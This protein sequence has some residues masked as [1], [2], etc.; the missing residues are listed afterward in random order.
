L[1]LNGHFHRARQR[2][3]LEVKRTLPE[4]AGMSANDPKRTSSHRESAPSVTGVPE[5]RMSFG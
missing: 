5:E 3:L 4:T 2:P 1:A